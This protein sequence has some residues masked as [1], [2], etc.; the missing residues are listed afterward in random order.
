MSGEHLKLKNPSF[1]GVSTLSP[2]CHSAAEESLIIPGGRGCAPSVGR[3][4][5]PIQGHR[6]GAFPHNKVIPPE[7]FAAPVPQDELLKFD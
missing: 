2:A 1:R 3:A 4:A 7:A 6:V 5:Q